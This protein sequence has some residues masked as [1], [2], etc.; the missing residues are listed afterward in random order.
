MSGYTLPVTFRRSAFLD[1]RAG[2]SKRRRAAATSALATVPLRLMLRARPAGA[3]FG[4]SPSR[5][6]ATCR[7][8]LS[9]LAA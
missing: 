1:G 4:G 2:P 3:G 9:R 5:P 6:A 8:C 7:P